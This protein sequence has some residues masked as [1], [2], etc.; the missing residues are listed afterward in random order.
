MQ[1]ISGSM[2]HAV[3][4]HGQCMRS[5]CDHVGTEDLSHLGGKESLLEAAEISISFEILLGK[6]L[7]LV[8]SCNFQ[9]NS[10]KKVL[11]NSRSYKANVSEEQSG[12]KSNVKV[13]INLKWLTI[14]FNLERKRR[15]ACRE[16]LPGYLED[17]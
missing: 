11:E 13:D 17:W 7:H 12:E 2:A 4:Y 3:G 6:A 5:P 9:Q 14:E 8:R 10:I 16:W 15:D 1:P